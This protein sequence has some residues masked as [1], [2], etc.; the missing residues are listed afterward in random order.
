M[1]IKRLTS[2]HH[3][4][5]AL[6]AVVFVALTTYSFPAAAIFEDNEARKAILDLRSQVSAG[7]QAQID[8]Q[9]QL[10]QAV[11]ENARL[12]GRTELLEKQVEELLAQQKS[13]Y[14][15]LNGRVNK[16][17]PQV[18]EIEGVQG[19]VQAGEKEAYES[20]LK[21]FQ[22]SNMKKAEAGFQSF[23]KKYPDS[24]YWP[25]AQFWLGNVN[26]AQK[27]YKTAIA[28]LQA[29]VKR[30]PLHVRTPDALLTIANSQVESGQKP[31]GKKTLESLIAK[32]PESEAAGLAKQALKRLK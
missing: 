4:T 7:Q 11:Q 31:A 13:F 20:A 18:L 2:L 28:S 15:D 17:E 1:Q 12:R 27:D 5:A 10:E 21:A 8:L 9:N 25:L 16:F 29:M 6:A 26:Y 14:Q 24:P 22:D 32:H 23:A 19:T 30:Y 3:Q